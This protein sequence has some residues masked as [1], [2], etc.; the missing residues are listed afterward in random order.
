M[1]EHLR[2]QFARVDRSDATTRTLTPRTRHWGVWDDAVPEHGRRGLLRY[3][4]VRKPS[5]SPT[6]S[7]ARH[8]NTAYHLLKATDARHRTP[9]RCDET[10]SPFAFELVRFLFGNCTHLQIAESYHCAVEQPLVQGAKRVVALL[11]EQRG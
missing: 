11:I 10:G 6:P 9:L 7:R 2:V 1:A 5:S 4:A 8:G 3:S